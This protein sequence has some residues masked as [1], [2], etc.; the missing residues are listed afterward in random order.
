MNKKFTIGAIIAFVV[1]LG[2][3]VSLYSMNQASADTVVTK[4]FCNGT[5]GAAYTLCVKNADIL[6]AEMAKRDSKRFKQSL[7]NM[8]NLRNFTPTVTVSTSPS[9]S[10]PAKTN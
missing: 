10:S 2:G 7:K 6:R 9:S 5:K 3:G 4:D 1:I 8:D